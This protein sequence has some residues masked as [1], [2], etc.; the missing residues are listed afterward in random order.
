MGRQYSVAAYL[1]LVERLRAAIP[2]IALTT[3][4]IVGFCGET[5]TQYEGT[6]ELL[7]AVRFDGVFAAAFSPRPGTPAARL[8]DDVPADVKR[9]RLNGLLALQEGIGLE[10]NRGWVGR[11]TQVLIDEVRPS[12]SHDHESP[13]GRRAAGGRAQPR[14]QA[15]APRRR[16]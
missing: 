2:G 1:E 3:D 13:D 12:R 6:L 11:R 10:R 15:G 5:E 8:D 9:R 16:P 7:R 14:E 4:V